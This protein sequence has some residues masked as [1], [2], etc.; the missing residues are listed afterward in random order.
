MLYK[1]CLRTFLRINLVSNSCIKTRIMED[2]GNY[3]SEKF[4]S[5]LWWCTPTIPASQEAGAGKPGITKLLFPVL[6][7]VPN[8]CLSCVF[9]LKAFSWGGELC[10]LNSRPLVASHVNCPGLTSDLNPPIPDSSAD[11]H[12]QYI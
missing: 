10:G 9:N 5:L 2:L 12:T 7:I 3:F 1:L 8:A 11:H 4:T 6:T